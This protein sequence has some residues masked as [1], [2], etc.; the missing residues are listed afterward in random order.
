VTSSKEAV[1]SIEQ[2]IGTS[3]P[4][5]VQPA[6]S[7]VTVDVGKEKPRKTV[8][9]TLPI[10]EAFSRDRGK[11]KALVEFIE[12]SKLE[13]YDHFYFVESRLS[14]DGKFITVP[15]EPN[16]FD[17]LNSKTGTFQT[18]VFLAIPNPET[19]PSPAIR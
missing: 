13:L 5:S 10:P 9:I 7:S 18:V 4:G 17:I 19:S 1:E 6:S 3:G 15:L 12:G 16:A 11:I 14:S 8:F 2:T